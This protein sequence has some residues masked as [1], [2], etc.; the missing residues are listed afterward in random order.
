MENHSNSNSGLLRFRSAPS[1]VFNDYTLNN[2]SDSDKFSGEQELSESY[3]RKPQRILSNS[4]NGYS[5]Q[6]PP[7]YPKQS[8]LGQ[9][10]RS[11]S[12]EISQSTTQVNAGGLSLSRQSSSPAGFFNNLNNPQNGYTVMRGLGSFRVGNGT[13]GDESI[14]SPRVTS[15]LSVSHLPQ[16]PELGIENGKEMSTDGF[17]LPSWT[18]SNTDA[19]HLSSE[20]GGLSGRPNMLSHHLSMP[21]TSAEMAVIEKLLHFQDTV[22]CKVRAKRG[23]ATHPRSIAERVRRNRISE[24]MRKLQD[25]VPNMDKQTN[26]ADMLDFAVDYIKN[27]QDQHRALSDNRARCKCVNLQRNVL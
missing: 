16:I 24:R 7:Q 14:V 9:L 10:Q 3:E 18:D 4:Q 26:T 27:L 25:L 15:R 12:S 5:G 11:N 21:N 13:N 2:W 20:N 23:C 6:L 19:S 1:S 8:N 22:P 17:S